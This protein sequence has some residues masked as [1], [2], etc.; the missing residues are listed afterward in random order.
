MDFTLEIKHI[1]HIIIIKN[2]ITTQYFLSV[3]K[4]IQTSHWNRSYQPLEPEH[5]HNRTSGGYDKPTHMC[6]ST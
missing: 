2:P 3:Y 1:I 5:K 4:K 6:V